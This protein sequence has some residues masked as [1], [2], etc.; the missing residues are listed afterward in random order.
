MVLYENPETR[1]VTRFNAAYHKY[2]STGSA[3][4]RLLQ[5]CMGQIPRI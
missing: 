4:K 1:H 3:G 5:P 2:V